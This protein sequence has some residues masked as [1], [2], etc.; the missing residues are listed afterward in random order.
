M[1]Y[2]IN[3]G[4]R[5]LGL[6]LLALVPSLLFVLHPRLIGGGNNPCY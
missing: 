1:P 4:N 6:P 5:V 2:L 3:K